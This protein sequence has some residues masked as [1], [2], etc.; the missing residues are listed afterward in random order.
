MLLRCPVCRAENAEGPSCRRCRADLSLLAAVQ[1][2]RANH[3]ATAA[4]AIR[5]GHFREGE[6]SLH[7]AERE[8]NGD[9]IRRIRACMFLL[10]GN[11]T[12]ALGEYMTIAKS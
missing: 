11:F 1:A 2:A 9:E 3:L 5:N 10:A 6:E 4:A 12:A 8:Q 7:R